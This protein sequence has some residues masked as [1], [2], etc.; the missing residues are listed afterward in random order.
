M[1][2]LQLNLEKAIEEFKKMAQ[3]ISDG[4]RQVPISHGNTESV[5]VTRNK[6]A[7][8][9]NTIFPIN[10]ATLQDHFINLMPTL[11]IC[12]S[13]KA[14]RT[15]W[16]LR[17]KTLSIHDTEA[18]SNDGGQL[19]PVNE[20]DRLLKCEQ[21]GVVLGAEKKLIMAIRHSE[22]NYDDI[23]DELGRF[24]YQPPRD[25]SGMLRYR[26]C[27]F[28]SKKIGI[29]YLIIA[30]MW[31]EYKL[32]S[33]INQLFILAPAKIIDFNDDLEDINKAIHHPLKL[34]LVSRSEAYESINLIKSFGT[35]DLGI[36]VRIPISDALAREWSYDKINST[37]KGRQIK[38]WAQKTGKKCP[39]EICQ[40]KHFSSLR[41]QD[42]AFGHII[43]Q[44]WSSAFTFILDKVHHPDNLYLTCK[45]CNSSLSDNFPDKTLKTK[46]SEE[47]T[48]GDWIRNFE[49][50]IRDH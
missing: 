29:P 6:V 32:S 1:S 41:S 47:G 25:T 11:A 7:A 33:E 34:Q 24:T 16:D 37:R 31:F 44:K 35:D 13:P 45:P 12:S 17:S 48:I 14:F 8:A 20:N 4:E 5:T 30:I 40:H 38:E 46:V 50:E 42:I 2:Q 18:V 9:L 39:G 49:K 23:L 43:S 27:Q 28:L 3:E 21:Q 26:W 19:I 15:A 22:G 36:D 10:A